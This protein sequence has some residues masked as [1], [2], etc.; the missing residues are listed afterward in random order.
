MHGPAVQGCLPAQASITTFCMWSIATDRSG[1]HP[2][3]LAS[4]VLRSRAALPRTRFSAT[5]R[6][7]VDA[8]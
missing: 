4:E 6:G 3:I 1:E 8:A 7:L 2:R 5:H